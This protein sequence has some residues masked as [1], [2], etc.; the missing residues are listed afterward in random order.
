MRNIAVL[1]SIFFSAGLSSCSI[2]CPGSIQAFSETQVVGDTI[3]YYYTTMESPCVKHDTVL[4]YWAK[5]GAIFSTQGTYNGRLL[6]GK[7]RKIVGSKLVEHGNFKRGLMDGEWKALNENRLT[8]VYTFRN[9]KLHGR[10][11]E[12]GED[13]N[14]SEKG[15]YFKGERVKYFLWW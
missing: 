9:G 11:A 7:Y 6:H 4:Y 10:F 8:S 3:I 15:K 13:G 2:F 12:Y 5:G 1:L 14:I